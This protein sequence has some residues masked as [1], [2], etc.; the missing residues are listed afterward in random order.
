MNEYRLPLAKE[1][2]LA[3]LEVKNGVRRIATSP[4][5]TQ[6]PGVGPVYLELTDGRWLCVHADQ[7]D[8]EAR[9][10]VFPIAAS[11][12]SSRPKTKLETEHVLEP[13]VSVTELETEDWLDPTVPCGETLGSNPVMQFQDLPGT[14]SATASAVCNYVSGVRFEG[15]NGRSVVLATLAFPYSVYCSVFPEGASQ[16]QSPHVQPTASAA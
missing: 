15:S 10:E 16:E 6:V 1:V 14:A 12:E 11:I 8:L 9:F 3:L 13:P 4:F 2:R 5:G 7:H